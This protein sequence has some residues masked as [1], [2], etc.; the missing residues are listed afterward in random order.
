[1]TPLNIHIGMSIAGALKLARFDAGGMA[2]FEISPQGFWRSFW[3]AGIVAPFFLLLLVLRH[4]EAGGAFG[5]HIVIESLAYVIAWLLF[6]TVMATVTR[7]LGC[8]QNF[9]PFIIAYNWAGAIQNGVYLPIAILGYTGA[10]SGE[11]ASFLALMAIAWVLIYTFFVV[12]TV[13]ELP[14]GTAVSI[15][16]L[17]FVLGLV[18][19][20]VTNQFL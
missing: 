2:F 16:V 15:V 8:A 9:V 17:D 12:R 10:L 5:H 6:P 11:S 19:D 4:I 20:G 14:A 1:M 18:V 7:M 3:A 13:L